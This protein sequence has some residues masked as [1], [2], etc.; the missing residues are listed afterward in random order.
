MNTIQSDDHQALQ[1]IICKSY[2]LSYQIAEKAFTRLRGTNYPYIDSMYMYMLRGAMFSK[3]KDKL[4]QVLHEMNLLGICIDF[5]MYVSLFEK[6]HE[7]C[8]IGDEI[9]L[10]EANDIIH[11]KAKIELD[12]ESIEL[13]TNKQ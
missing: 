2:I 10:K 11:A 4:M 3:N 13:I 12:K 6:Q 5:S 8:F 9:L 1:M 7:L